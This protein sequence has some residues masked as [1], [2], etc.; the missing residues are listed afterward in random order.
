MSDTSSAL[1]ATALSK[2]FGSTSVLDKVSLNIR[3]GDRIAVIGP[4]G[5]GKSTLLRILSGLETPDSGTIRRIPS[6]LTVAYVPQEIDIGLDETLFD[7]FARRTGVSKAEEELQAFASR[8]AEEPEVATGYSAALER[9]VAAGASD[10]EARARTI[11]ARLGLHAPLGRPIKETSGGEAARVRLAATM[12]ARF[13][14]F[15]LDEP[16]NDLDFDGLAALESFLASC[17]AAVVVSHDRAFL[18]RTVNQVLEIEAETRR[19]RH[20]AGG[21]HDFERARATDLAHAAQAYHGHSSEVARFKSLLRNRREEARRGGSQANRRATNA[22][23]SKARAAQKRL[24]QLEQSGVEKPWSPWRLHLEFEVGSRPGNVVLRLEDAVIQ[25][26]DI[27]LGPLQLQIGWGDRVALIG[28]NG[29]GKSALLDALVGRLV[30][31]SGS[32]WAGPSVRI[33]HLDQERALVDR[34]M[35]VLNWFS[36]EVNLPLV[37]ARTLLGRFNLRE[38]TVLR[39]ASL[40]SPGERTRVLLALLQYGKANVLALDEPTNHLDLEAVEQLEQA[41]ALFEGTILLVTHDQRLLD[42]FNPSHTIDVEAITSDGQNALRR[43]S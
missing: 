34:R 38:M 11:C 36:E 25:R 26:G 6:D 9:L 29:A 42:T 4:N 23:A 21:F 14:V 39:P 40:L 13:D 22:L 2:S 1:L 30:L 24:E 20:Y 3:P 28:R 43:S 17:P 27:R 12:L 7:Y 5:I 31:S 18:E 19:V 37:E 33:G 15:L 16:T 35:P 8:L 32:R 41:L 10:F